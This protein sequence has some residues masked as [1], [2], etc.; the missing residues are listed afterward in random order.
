MRT[1]RFLLLKSKEEK[2]KETHCRYLF[3]RKENAIK[4][5]QKKIL[6]KQLPRTTGTRTTYSIPTSRTRPHD[7]HTHKNP[8]RKRTKNFPCCWS[9]QARSFGPYC[10]KD[11]AR[12]GYCAPSVVRPAPSNTPRATTNTPSSNSSSNELQ[13][14][15]RKTLLSTTSNGTHIQPSRTAC[16]PTL[17]NCLLSNPLELSPNSRKAFSHVRL[18]ST[19]TSLSN[20]DPYRQSCFFQLQPNKLLLPAPTNKARTQA[21]RL[22]L[23]SYTDLI[24]QLRPT[25]FRLRRLSYASGPASWNRLVLGWHA[26]S[27]RVS[28]LSANR[29][30]GH[31]SCSSE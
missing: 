11:G 20:S 30:S 2:Q 10:G 15:Q 31:A 7:T 27:G 19:C 21:S 16:F 23:L 8:E 28:A 12:L 25:P 24:I 13:L 6:Q 26:P 17:S 29:E 1:S 3:T 22:R 18:S 4:Y 14:H 5:K 9:R